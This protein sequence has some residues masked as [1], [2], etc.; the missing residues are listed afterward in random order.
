MIDK[1][2]VV[3]VLPKIIEDIDGILKPLVAQQIYLQ[4]NRCSVVTIDQIAHLH[5]IIKDNPYDYDDI[6]IG[7]IYQS[8]FIH[9]FTDIF[10]A[11]EMHIN[12][13]IE[14]KGIRISNDLADNYGLTILIL[15]SLLSDYPK[16]ASAIAKIK[17][18]I[19]KPDH[20]RSFDDSIESILKHIQITHGKEVTKAFR[21]DVRSYLQCMRVIRNKLSHSQVDLTELEIALFKS[22]PAMRMILS[23]SNKLLLSVSDISKIISNSINL[24]RKFD[25]YTN[26]PEK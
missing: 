8:I 14:R 18:S 3:T 4:I 1:H 15:E 26:V 12:E 21:N 6:L 7:I 10:I 2:A 25:E 9:F 23:E 16:I 17:K 20:R 22:Q 5:R 11:F 19:R 13:M 24:L